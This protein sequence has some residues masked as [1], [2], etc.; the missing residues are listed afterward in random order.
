VRILLTGARGLIGSALTRELAG[1]GHE[2]RQLVR[3]HTGAPDEFLW[4]PAAGMLD[5]RALD[6]VD[7][8]IHL[9]GEPIAAGRWTRRR[10]RAI[11]E[12]REQGTGLLARA[13]ASS[14]RPPRV[15]LSASAI[16]A[17][18]DR[19]D[20]LLDERSPLGNDF[21]AQ[22]CRAWEGATAPAAAAG[23]RVVTPRFG[24]VLAA[25]GGA[26]ARQLP[27]FRAGLGGRLGSGQQWMSVIA[28]DDLIGALTHLLAAEQ[29]SGPVNLV[30]AEPVRNADYTRLLGRLLRRPA[31]LPVPRPALR[32]AFGELADTVLLASQR[33]IP[34]A[35]LASG[36]RLRHP[37][38]LDALRAAL[39]S[40][41]RG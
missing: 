38:P 3:R 6:G 34:A 36:Y 7:A 14:G 21:L 8:V 12:S 4:D 41:A 22:V 5:T 24:I 27:F 16:G 35:L 25:G 28:L 26:L 33:A 31:F 30:A 2:L 15:L 32:L 37:S 9:A 10:K 17:Y 11:L 20:E 23:V 19:G 29:V 1:R 18:G 40:L 13:V 39:G